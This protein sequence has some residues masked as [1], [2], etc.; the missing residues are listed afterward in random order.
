MVST[1]TGVISKISAPEGPL[2]M[3]F[4]KVKYIAN[5][6]A[7]SIISAPKKIQKPKIFKLFSSVLY[8]SGSELSIFIFLHLAILLQFLQFPQQK[9]ID[10]D[11]SQMN[12]KPNN[13]KYRLT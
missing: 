4:S 12:D 2:P 7:K 10:H 11:P 13:P 3:R 1:N 9:S 6:V 8:S 5:N